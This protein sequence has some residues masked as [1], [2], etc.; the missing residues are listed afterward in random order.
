MTTRTMRLILNL[1]PALSVLS[2]EELYQI[3]VALA[4]ELD[5]RQ[6]PAALAAR[7][8]AVELLGPARVAHREQLIADV[9]GPR[10]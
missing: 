6:A 7:T 10:P 2:A 3:A 9:L 1:P 8:L 5:R 4:D